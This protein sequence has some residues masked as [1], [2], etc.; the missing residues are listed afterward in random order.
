M[1]LPTT[2]IFCLAIKTTSLRQNLQQPPTT[3]TPPPNG[4]RASLPGGFCSAVH[5]RDRQLQGIDYMPWLTALCLAVIEYSI[6]V[7]RMDVFKRLL[8]N[9]LPEI[10]NDGGR[11]MRRQ[12]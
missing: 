4:G 12:R 3:Q 6:C 1:P 8:F 7:P 9:Q 10:G 2:R 5:A 11:E